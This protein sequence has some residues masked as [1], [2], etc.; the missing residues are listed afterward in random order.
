MW[1]YL[2]FMNPNCY[3]VKFLTGA[4]DVCTSSW[5]T[6]MH[7]FIFSYFTEYTWVHT[8]YEDRSFLV[9]VPYGC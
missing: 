5:G 1:P 9:Q 7:F 2:W 8:P 4:N 6:L 3:F